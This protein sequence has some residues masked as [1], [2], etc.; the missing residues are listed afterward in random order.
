VAGIL[1]MPSDANIVVAME[2]LERV[3]PKLG[4]TLRPFDIKAVDD[5]STAFARMTPSGVQG[6]LV[7]AGTFTYTHGRRIAEL[8]AAHHLP[9]APAFPHTPL[10]PAPIHLGPTPLS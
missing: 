4:I 8:A 6:V 1:R 5:L 9:S 2:S 3:A 10:P 7:V